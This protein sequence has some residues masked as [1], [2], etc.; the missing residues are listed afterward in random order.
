MAQT[1]RPA[2]FHFLLFVCMRQ[3]SQTRAWCFASILMKYALKR[4]GNGIGLVCQFVPLNVDFISQ[5]KAIWLSAE[6]LIKVRNLSSG[7]AIL[8]WIF[9]ML[10]YYKLSPVV[11]HLFPFLMLLISKMKC[12][13][14]F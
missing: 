1:D 3:T 5:S 11:P 6:I 2:L 13:D 12:K 9:K 10:K 7:I 4:G 8:I 14:Q